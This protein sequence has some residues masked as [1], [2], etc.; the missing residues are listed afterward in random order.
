VRYDWP[1]VTVTVT[2]TRLDGAIHDIFL[3]KEPVRQEAY[4]RMA[5]WLRAYL[6]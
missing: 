2:I 6:K 5:Q 1:T 4:R 3:S